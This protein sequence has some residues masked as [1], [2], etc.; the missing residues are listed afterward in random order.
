MIEFS[1]L[2]YLPDPFGV[3]QAQFCIFTGSGEIKWPTAQEVSRYEGYLISYELSTLVDCFRSLKSAPPINLIDIEQ[4]LYLCA[5]T[6]RD[7][8]GERKR[9]IWYEFTK[10]FDDPH[11]ALGFKKLFKSQSAWSDTE[12]LSSDLEAAVRALKELWLQV[13]ERLKKSNEWERFFQIEVPVQGI[14]NHRQYEGIPIDL[15]VAQDLISK[16]TNEKYIA[17]QEVAK[18]I[19]RSPEGLNFWNIHPYLKSTDASHLCEIK[20][21]GILRDSF[22]LASNTSAFAKNFLKY[23]DSSRD[24][25]IIKRAV[26]A[27]GKL[28]PIFQT[29]GTVTGRILV[30]DPYLQQLSRPYRALIVA[31]NGMR[32]IYLDYCQFEPGILA[33]LSQD[34]ALID[35]YNEGDIYM[36]LSN[37]VFGSDA[38]RSISKR[39]FLAFSYGMTPERIAQLISDHNATRE[40]LA[41]IEKLIEDFFAMFPGLQRFRAS[42]ENQLA[43]SGFVSSLLGNNRYR[44]RHGVLTDKEKRWALNQPIQATASLIFK[45]SLIGLAKRFGNQAILLPVHDAV[46]MQ[47]KNEDDFMSNVKQAEQIMLDAF[48]HR[49]PMITARISVSESF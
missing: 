4:A 32:L 6:P 11:D 10:S 5:G 30:S 41:S 44:T 29:I 24:E 28:F 22:K 12:N 2:V 16:V 35:A 34:R 18:K 47:F 7:E 13:T 40:K 42:M 38:F 49:C 39:I 23:T 19:S 36:A 9:S 26:N 17:F 20:E 31:D 14:F 33:S 21:G 8:G 46:L 15:N 3:R 37:K 48:H 27:E 1:Y 43:H 25:L 45:E